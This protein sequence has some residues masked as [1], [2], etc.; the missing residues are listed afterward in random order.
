MDVA[1]AVS[2]AIMGPW[3]IGPSSYW[4][5]PE[6]IKCTNSQDWLYSLKN[7]HSAIPM[8][9]KRVNLPTLK[10]PVWNRTNNLKTPCENQPRSDDSFGAPKAANFSSQGSLYISSKRGYE[11]S[12]KK[13]E[14]KYNKLNKETS[15]T[16]SM[17]QSW[18]VWTTYKKS[19][20]C[21]ALPTEPSQTINLGV[22]K[23]TFD[24]INSNNWLLCAIINRY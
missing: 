12:Y 16:I 24:T 8:C 10:T 7:P 13:Q 18:W 22:L 11:S 4:A 17:S 5:N 15:V 14:S 9:W 3:S 21:Q 23:F 6:W 2:T 19:Q 20:L 1:C